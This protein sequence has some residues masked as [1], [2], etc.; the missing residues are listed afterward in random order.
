MMNK[1]PRSMGKQEAHGLE[2]SEAQE[3]EGF[4]VRKVEL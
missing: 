1:Y 4:R 2:A 3:V